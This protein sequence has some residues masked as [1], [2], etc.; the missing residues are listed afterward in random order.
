MKDETVSELAEPK[1]PSSD[2]L[3]PRVYKAMVVLAL[4]LVLSAWGFFT[5]RGYIVLA[6]SVVTWLCAVAVVLPSVLAA[7]GRGD[8]ARR[9]EQRAGLPLTFR[10]WARGDFACSGG[11][12]RGSLA[13]IEIFVPL[14]AVAIGMTLFALVREIVVS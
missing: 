8:A 3:H 2:A 4:W 5:D 10:D 6:L 13:A 1:G 14:A 11:R 12:I 7:I 9:T